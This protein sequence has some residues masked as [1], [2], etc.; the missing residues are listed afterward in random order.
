MTN[1]KNII[2]A[3]RNCN[4]IVFPDRSINI[5]QSSNMINK[6]FLLS[7]DL[8]INKKY[9]ILFELDVNINPHNINFSFDINNGTKTNVN[10]KADK[11]HQEIEHE[12]IFDKYNKDVYD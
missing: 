9:R 10:N 6:T 7:D 3:N 8:I 12:I 1:F 4:K 2:I 11:Q 5:Q